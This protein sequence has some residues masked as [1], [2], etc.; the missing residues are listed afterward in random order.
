MAKL[1]S[2]QIQ[3]LCADFET[4]AAAQTIARRYG[5]AP[6]TV[7]YHAYANGALRPDMARYK[8][9]TG[10][11]QDYVRNGRRVRVFT[12]A[13]DAAILKARSENRAWTDIAR[14]LRRPPSS[15]RNRAI[16]LGYRELVIEEGA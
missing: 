13:E 16:M 2:D 15:V 12:P 4:G 8:A 6:N 9:H 11:Q 10:R 14:T 3:D 1:T 5:V 7:L